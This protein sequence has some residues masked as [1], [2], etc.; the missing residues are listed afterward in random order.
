MKNTFHVKMIIYLLIFI[1]SSYYF[2]YSNMCHCTIKTTIQTLHGR[3]SLQKQLYVYCLVTFML[4]C[5]FRKQY[6]LYQ[7]NHN[8]TVTLMSVFHTTL[9]YIQHNV[10]S[11]LIDNS[12]HLLPTFS[13]PSTQLI[14]IMSVCTHLEAKFQPLLMLEFAV[15]SSP[16][17]LHLLWV[18]LVVHTIR[19]KDCNSHLNASIL[20]IML[21]WHSFQS[22]INVP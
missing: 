11:Q 12:I 2:V 15:L 6:P 14:Y 19:L 5:L 17:C 4:R 10:W 22:D 1:F 20:Y 21:L 7:T 9:C 13:F 3:I 18:H 16:Q 8:R